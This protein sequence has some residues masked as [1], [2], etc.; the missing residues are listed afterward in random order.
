MPPAENP[1]PSD[2]DVLQAL[3]ESGVLTEDQARR[4]RVAVEGGMD[5]M[6]SVRATPLVEPLQLLRARQNAVIQSKIRAQSSAQD[7]SPVVVP[8]SSPD[9]DKPITHFDDADVMEIEFETDL[10]DEGSKPTMKL[11]APNLSREPAI[12]RPTTEEEEL[13]NRPATP[14]EDKIAPGITDT[15]M[16]EMD[17]DSDTPQAMVRADILGSDDELMLDDEPP[18]GGLDNEL[19]LPSDPTA[20]EYR[21]EYASREA[22]KKQAAEGVKAPESLALPADSTGYRKPNQAPPTYNLADDEGINLIKNV[23][24]KLAQAIAQKRA[25]LWLGVEGD[26]ALIGEYGPGGK[27]QNVVIEDAELIRKMINRLKIMA[28]IQPWRTEGGQGAFH[29][30]NQ[31]LDYTGLV[32]ASSTG[33]LESVLVTLRPGKV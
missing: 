19:I 12:P 29:A 4:V 20:E 18:S 1:S 5:L 7:N 23:N 15:M 22:V 8:M 3:L 28:R 33:G 16:D 9:D 32:E 6:D 31:G 25:A 17:F 10:D 14:K 30:L 21:E 2:L 27:R 13:M 24:D 11:K 26:E